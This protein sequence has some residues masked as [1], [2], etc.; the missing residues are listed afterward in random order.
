MSF[1]ARTLAT[2]LTRLS[3]ALCPLAL[4]PAP[5]CSSI[6]ITVERAKPQIRGVILSQ[7][8]EPPSRTIPMTWELANANQ[9]ALASRYA[10]EWEFARSPGREPGP[11]QLGLALS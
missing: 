5:G 8:Q 3:L 1:D 6:G 10:P 4:L 9:R 2:M 7:E 11:P